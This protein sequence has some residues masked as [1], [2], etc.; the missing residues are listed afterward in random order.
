M[1]DIKNL[2]KGAD[3]LL[4]NCANLKLYEKLLIIS[5]DEK[6]GWYKK[7]IAEF[8]FNDAKSRDINVDILYVGEPSNDNKKELKSKINEYDCTIFFC[9][10]WR[11]R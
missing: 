3:N 8:V 7:D 10:N 11:S 6:F 9:T 4:T 5:E 2:K 1:S